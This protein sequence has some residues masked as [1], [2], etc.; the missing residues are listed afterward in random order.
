[1]CGDI[2]TIWIVVSLM[3]SHI[4]YIFMYLL[5]IWWKKFSY[6]VICISHPG[7]CMV[8]AWTFL[9][10]R[11]I[12]LTACQTSI[13]FNQLKKKNAVTRLFRMSK[14]EG[15][16]KGSPSYVTNGSTTEDEVF[17]PKRQCCAVF[18]R[19]CYSVSFE[20]LKGCTS[21]V[22][23]LFFVLTRYKTV[24][25][26]RHPRVGPGGHCTCKFWTCS[27]IIESWTFWTV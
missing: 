13:C 12:C 18:L 17:L 25:G 11:A 10:S 24:D 4:E 19:A 2:L 7:L 1:M 15:R 16:D 23:C 20:T 6:S 9:P 8:L 14:F 27:C 22:W 5:I 26:S 21:H 3:V